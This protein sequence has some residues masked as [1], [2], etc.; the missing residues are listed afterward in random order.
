MTQKLFAFYSV[1]FCILFNI[2]L[3]DKNLEELPKTVKDFEGSNVAIQ[4]NKIINSFVQEFSKIIVDFNQ[5]KQMIANFKIEGVTE[6]RLKCL[7]RIIEDINIMTHYTTRYTRI[8]KLILKWIDLAI[9]NVKFNFR[10]ELR[11]KNINSLKESI[12]SIYFIFISS[13]SYPTF[14]F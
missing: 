14:I 7:M 11:N 6:A 10:I 2:N 12:N 9:E 1:L 13:Y 3:F 4:D 5:I 8:Q